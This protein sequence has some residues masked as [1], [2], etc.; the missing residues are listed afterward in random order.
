[1]NSEFIFTLGQGQFESNH[2][3]LL[4]KAAMSNNPVP[5]IKADIPRHDTSICF[6]QF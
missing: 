1:M 4:L 6:L 3:S 5:G 2:I